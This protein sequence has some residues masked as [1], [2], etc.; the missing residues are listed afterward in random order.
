MQVETD[1]NIFSEPF[2]ETANIAA[3]RAIY[4]DF[5]KNYKDDHGG[6][7]ACQKAW[8]PKSPI[9]ETTVRFEAYSTH[10]SNLK[11]CNVNARE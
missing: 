3:S 6:P 8:N 4:H 9:T 5:G 2:L 1:K 11:K 10:E 7:S